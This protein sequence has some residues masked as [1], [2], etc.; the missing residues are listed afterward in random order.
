MSIRCSE[1]NDHDTMIIKRG[2]DTKN[3]LSKCESRNFNKRNLRTLP[4]VA[5]DDQLLGD[6]TMECQTQRIRRD[7]GMRRHTSSP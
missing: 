5:C 6:I 4:G 2:R 1:G 7:G 3:L